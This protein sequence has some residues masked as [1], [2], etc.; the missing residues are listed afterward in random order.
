VRR[1]SLFIHLAPEK[2]W[3]VNNPKELAK[4]LQRLEAIQK[5]FNRPA[6]GGKKVSLA[7][8]IVMGGSAAVAADHAPSRPWRTPAK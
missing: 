5:D 6:S 8:L 3:E 7:D 4:M 2:D 1:D